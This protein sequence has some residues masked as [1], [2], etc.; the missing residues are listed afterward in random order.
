[1]RPG[2]RGPID[3]EDAA[4][5]KVL[6]GSMGCIFAEGVLGKYIRS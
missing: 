2:G 1:M 6:L 4:Q 5:L 3:V